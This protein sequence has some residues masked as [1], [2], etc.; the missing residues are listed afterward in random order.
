MMITNTKPT[1]RRRW[2]MDTGASRHMVNDDPWRR[3][4]TCAVRMCRVE[5]PY[6][7]FS[8]WIISNLNC[9]LIV[10]Q[11]YL[12]TCLAAPRWIVVGFFEY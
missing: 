9:A 4:T 3:D 10:P 5:I 1:K 12:R 6:E 2:L 8:V 11:R 7:I